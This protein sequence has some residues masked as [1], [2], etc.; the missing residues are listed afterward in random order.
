MTWKGEV[1]TAKS[2]SVTMDVNN[3]GIDDLEVVF[4]NPGDGYD[5]IVGQI[6]TVKFLMKR[7]G[8]CFMNFIGKLDRWRHQSLIPQNNRLTDSGVVRRVDDHIDAR[9]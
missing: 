6:I 7:R 5:L 1:V 2:D 8:G 4:E 9:R 3:F